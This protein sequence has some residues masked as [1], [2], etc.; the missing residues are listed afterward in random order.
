MDSNMEIIRITISTDAFLSDLKEMPSLKIGNRLIELEIGP[1]SPELQEVAKKELRESPEVQKEAIARFKELL[2]AETNLK[3]PLDNEA[4]LIRF[5]RPCKYYP[6]SALKLV[7]HYYSFKMKH[8]NIYENL[9]ASREKNIFDQNILTVLPIRDQHGRRML[10][11]ELGKK[12]KHQKC[13]L[14]EVFKG[15]VLYLET[16]ILEPS[17][18]IAGTIVIFDMDGLTLQQ[19][20]QFTPPF[21]KKIVDL[22]QDAVPLR[23]KNLHVINQPYVFNMVFALFKP[24]L[25][26]KLKSRIIFHGTDRKS[27]HQYISPKC[28]PAHYGGTMEVPLIDGPTWYELL[29]QC[30]KEY[31]AINSYGYKKK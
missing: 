17:T 15:C 8:A 9:K 4:W 5:L 13:S 1:P 25:R 30:D 27:L 11:I 21:A 18:Q 22:I 26:E 19:A 3:C 23:I 7:K 29:V 20:W 10:I 28:L 12:W 16:A 24:F 31:E 14:D 6:E 2:K